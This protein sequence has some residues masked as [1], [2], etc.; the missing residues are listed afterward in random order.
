MD[1]KNKK[2]INSN[3]DATP[4]EQEQFADAFFESEAKDLPHLPERKDTDL[5]SD[6]EDSAYAFRWEPFETEAQNKKGNKKNT[7]WIHTLIMAVSFITAFAIL[8][9]VFIANKTEKTP[10]SLNS[11]SE[12]TDKN[13]DEIAETKT[14][15]IKE[16]DSTKGA[17]TPQEIYAYR[18]EAVISI[19]ASNEASK[20]I[21]SGFVIDPSGY[22][23]TAHHVISGMK[24][25]SVIFK[26]GKKYKAEIVASDELTDI[27]LLKIDA[28]DLLAVE[29]GKSSELLVGDELLAI[30]TPA[31]LEFSGTMTRGD[32]SFT[33]RT[34]YVS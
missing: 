13:N 31:S 10:L 14:V 30:G 33:N 15:F 28:T 27:A 4:N 12:N 23:A 9:A 19:S 2:N 26:N 20:G 5:P 25:I 6:S 17:M 21:G 1:E 24:E 22:I 32:V 29:F 16:F 7:L 34:V 3:S 18:S 8:S 11:S